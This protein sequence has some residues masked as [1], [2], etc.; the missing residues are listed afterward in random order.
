MKTT[1]KE[2]KNIA[3]FGM[4][5]DSTNFSEKDINELQEREG[6]LENIAISFGN[7]GMN[8]GLFEARNTRKKFVILSRNT[9]LF[10]L[11]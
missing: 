3:H 11:A 4:A 9:N 7:Y 5:E 10:R 8:G 2:L 1:L 6:T